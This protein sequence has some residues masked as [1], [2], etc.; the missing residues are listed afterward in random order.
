M[1]YVLGNLYNSLDNEI[2]AVRVFTLIDHIDKHVRYHY[3]TV[4]NM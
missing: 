4:H 3:N 2:P 1:I